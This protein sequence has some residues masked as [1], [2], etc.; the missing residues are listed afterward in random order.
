MEIILLN[1]EPVVKQIV[2]VLLVK[3]HFYQKTEKNVFFPFLLGIKETE[4]EKYAMKGYLAIR[5]GDILCVPQSSNRTVK[6]M[7]DLVRLKYIIAKV[8]YFIQVCKLIGFS[9]GAQYGK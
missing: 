5:E 4:S 8:N 2:N 6:H 1:K 3:F 7:A 9:R